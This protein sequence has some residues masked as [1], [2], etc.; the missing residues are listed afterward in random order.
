M[1]TVNTLQAKDKLLAYDADTVSSNDYLGEA[2]EDP[3]ESDMK[4]A[5]LM[6]GGGGLLLTDKV[7]PD[8]LGPSV[9]SGC[10]LGT[11]LRRSHDVSNRRY[12]QTALAM[13]THREGYGNIDRRPG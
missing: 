5:C 2:V 1:A 6:D 13:R 3:L 10:N 4:D 9:I 7:I 12:C 11:L 8:S